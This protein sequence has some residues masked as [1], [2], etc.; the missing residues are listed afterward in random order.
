MEATEIIRATLAKPISFD[1]GSFEKGGTSSVY[2][3]IGYCDVKKN[4]S[5]YNCFYNSNWQS[6]LLKLLRPIVV[7]MYISDIHN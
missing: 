6:S 2:V 4:S 3:Y 7:K 5:T 1:F